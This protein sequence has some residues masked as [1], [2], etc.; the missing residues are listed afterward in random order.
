MLLSQDPGDNSWLT[1]I[2]LGLKDILTS[3]LDS[4][5]RN[6][7]LHLA[8]ALCRLFGLEWTLTLGTQFLVLLVNLFS[9]VS[10]VCVDEFIH[11]V[12]PYNI[13][14]LKYLAH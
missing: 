10:L 11:L 2:V 3:K 4:A 12:S 7:S 1:D 5:H 8:A 13:V 9:V 14:A 6:P